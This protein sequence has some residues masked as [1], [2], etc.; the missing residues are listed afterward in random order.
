MNQDVPVVIR[1]G[2]YVYLLNMRTGILFH[3]CIYRRPRLVFCGEV[4]HNRKISEYLTSFYENIQ[5][6]LR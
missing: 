4:F 2:I 3:D 6:I 5:I 1:F